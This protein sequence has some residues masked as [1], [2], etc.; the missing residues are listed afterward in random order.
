MMRNFAE[1]FAILVYVTV[2]YCAVAAGFMWAT[3]ML[4]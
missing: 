2:A 3:G 4:R 1:W